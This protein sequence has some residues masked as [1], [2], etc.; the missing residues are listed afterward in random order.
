VFTLKFIVIY[1]ALFE[2][3][4]FYWY[5]AVISSSIVV[6]VVVRRAYT[7]RHKYRVTSAPPSRLSL[8]KN[9]FSYRRNSPSSLSGRRSSGGKLFQIRGLAAGK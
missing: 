4:L 3:K 9:V 6:V 8:N 7:R 2:P 1:T 5:A